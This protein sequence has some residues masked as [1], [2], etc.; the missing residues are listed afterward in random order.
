MRKPFKQSLS[1]VLVLALVAAG[2]ALLPA[3]DS[4]QAVYAGTKSKALKLTKKKVVLHP[5]DKITIKVKN[6]K[7]KVKWTTSNKKL[8]TVTQTGLV[9]IAKKAKPGKTVK[10][11]PT[12]GLCSYYAERGG[13]IVG[14]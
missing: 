8:A 6:A 2:L 12:R 11:I 3:A 14:F 5:G 4:G 9:K 1:A 13:I 7:K 10:I